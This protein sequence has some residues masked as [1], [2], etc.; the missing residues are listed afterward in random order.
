MIS[1]KK[2]KKKKAC[3]E[4]SPKPKRAFLPRECFNLLR[5]KHGKDSHGQVQRVHTRAEG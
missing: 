3:E 2:K 4:Q 1:K 5:E